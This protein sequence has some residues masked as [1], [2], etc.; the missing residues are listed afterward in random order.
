MRSTIR[1][2]HQQLTPQVTLTHNMQTV[3]LAL[4]AAEVSGRC[5]ACL[6]TNSLTQTQSA[7]L[8]LFSVISPWSP[9]SCA[10]A[11]CWAVQCCTLSPAVAR[12]A[13]HPHRHHTVGTD[14]SESP[15]LPRTAHTPG[16][17][18]WSKGREGRAQW[19]GVEWVGE[20]GGTGNLQWRRKRLR[21]RRGRCKGW[22][23]RGQCKGWH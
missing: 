15:A 4:Q 5:G 18:T 6:C 12:S 13:A 20:G 1:P 22:H 3:Q 11:I 10:P 21:S 8:S 23:R 7:P 16:D 17:K 2:R 19:S 14:T 9:C